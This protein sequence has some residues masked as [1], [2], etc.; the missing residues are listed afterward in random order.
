[1]RGSRR[2][3]GAG[4]WVT[5]EGLREDVRNAAA[6]GVTMS[7]LGSVSFDADQALVSRSRREGELETHAGHRES[8]A[9]VL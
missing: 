4:V 2:Q 9:A 7:G 5:W 1:M 6:F 8:R 3:S